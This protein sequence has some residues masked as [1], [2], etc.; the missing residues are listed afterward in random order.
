MDQTVRIT[1]RLPSD[2]HEALTKTAE[3]NN[4]SMNGEIVALLQKGMELAP[5][6]L[7][8]QELAQMIAAYKVMHQEERFALADRVKKLGGAEQVAKSS[9]ISLIH[10]ALTLDPEMAIDTP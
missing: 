8:K 10:D 1:L 4:R 2:L 7:V 6:D 5:F 3:K 9:S